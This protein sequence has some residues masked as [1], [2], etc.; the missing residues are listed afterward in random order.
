MNVAANVCI[1]FIRVAITKLYA[2]HQN[3]TQ[4]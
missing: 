4:I 3:L 2:S 1:L